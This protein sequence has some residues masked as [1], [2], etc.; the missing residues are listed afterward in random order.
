MAMPRFITGKKKW[1][2][3]FWEHSKLL[4]TRVKGVKPMIVRIILLLAIGL[5]RLAVQLAETYLTVDELDTAMAYGL[6]GSALE[7]LIIRCN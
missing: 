7:S 5:L 2:L 6:K 3:N 4:H 1:Y